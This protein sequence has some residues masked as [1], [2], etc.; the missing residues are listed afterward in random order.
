[1]RCRFIRQLLALELSIFIGF[2]NTRQRHGKRLR[3]VSTAM[4]K[5]QRFIM[6]CPSVTIT[7]T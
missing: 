1:M 7:S 3:G 2:E 4:T 6:L 5:L